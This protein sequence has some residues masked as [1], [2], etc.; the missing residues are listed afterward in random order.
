MK[1]KLKRILLAIVALTVA[2][3]CVI[4]C[5]SNIYAASNEY[6][7]QIKKNYISEYVAYNIAQRFI[8]NAVENK[9]AE[10]WNEYTEAKLLCKCYDTNGNVSAYVYNIMD[11]YLDIF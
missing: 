9:I 5:T 6:I 11:T 8:V 4:I 3:Y 7:E 10:N 2:N 1:E